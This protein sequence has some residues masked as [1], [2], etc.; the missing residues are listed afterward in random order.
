MAVFKID[1]TG[2]SESDTAL[3]KFGAGV[4]DWRHVA[5]QDAAC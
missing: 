1:V 4:E 2:V 3:R 5:A